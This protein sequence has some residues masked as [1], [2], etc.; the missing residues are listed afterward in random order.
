M[1]KAVEVMQS[2][3][4]ER[5]SDGKKTPAVGAV[6]VKP[7][8]EVETACR[9]EIRN[10]DHAEYTLIERKNRNARLDGSTLFEIASI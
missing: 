8:G 9:G 3:I 10:G 5:R 4:V 7:N 1:E 2:S 6:L